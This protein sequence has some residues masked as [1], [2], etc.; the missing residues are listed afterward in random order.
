MV[1]GLL[2]FIM[3]CNIGIIIDKVMIFLAD[4][5]VSGIMQSGLCNPSTIN[6]NGLKEDLTLNFLKTYG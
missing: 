2:W 4:R 3:V 1:L 6:Y 5:G